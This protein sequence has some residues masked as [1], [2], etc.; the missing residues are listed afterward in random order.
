MDK[1]HPN[2]KKTPTQQSRVE[3]KKCPMGWVYEIDGHFNANDAV[4]PESIV[5]AW[6]VDPAGE[7]VGE[8]IPNPKYRPDFGKK[9]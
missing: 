3:A 2:P 4:P 1:G 8:C 6:K 7:I 5:G 9:E